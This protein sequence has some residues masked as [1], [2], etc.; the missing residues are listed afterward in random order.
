VEAR[1]LTQDQLADESGIDIRPI[2]RI[3]A[4]E[5]NP[6]LDLVISLT[7]VGLKMGIVQIGE[8]FKL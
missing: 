7:T 1:G 4:C 5:Q 6:S 2:Q 8:L 3:E